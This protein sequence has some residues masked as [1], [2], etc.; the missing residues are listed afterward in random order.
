MKSDR[1]Q[2]AFMQSNFAKS[3]LEEEEEKVWWYGE[4]SVNLLN[5]FTKQTKGLTARLEAL[6]LVPN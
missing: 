3:D 4:D 1:E 6:E 5:A 2:Q